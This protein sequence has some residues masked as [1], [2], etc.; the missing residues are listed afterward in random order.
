MARTRIMTSTGVTISTKINGLWKW[1]LSYV[2]CTLHSLGKCWM[3]KSQGFSIAIAPK[4]FWEPLDSDTKKRVNH[5][6]LQA[7]K[8]DFPTNNWRCE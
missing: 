8:F 1:R 5:W 4:V 2:V 3:L 7:N 6:L